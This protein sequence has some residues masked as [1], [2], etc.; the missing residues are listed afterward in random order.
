[1]SYINNKNLDSYYIDFYKDEFVKN[2][3]TNK[4]DKTIE[5]SINDVISLL[6]E[7]EKV[8]NFLIDNKS[9]WKIDGENISFNSNILSN[10]YNELINNL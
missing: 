4:N 7:S 8:I 5:N 10:Q 1:M 6:Q 9:S 2:I 3:K